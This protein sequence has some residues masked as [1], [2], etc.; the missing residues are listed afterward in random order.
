M[1]TVTAEMESPERF[2]R[3]VLQQQ[4]T[5]NE[6]VIMIEINKLLTNH[7]IM[8][9]RLVLLNQACQPIAPF[10]A[11]YLHM[12]YIKD[13]LR[14]NENG[15]YVDEN[16]TAVA[17]CKDDR[18]IEAWI[19]GDRLKLMKEMAKVDPLG[20]ITATECYDFMSKYIMYLHAH[21]YR[22]AMRQ[23][24]NGRNINYDDPNE[25]NRRK[26][27]TRTWQSRVQDF[28]NKM[29]KNRGARGRENENENE[30]KNENENENKNENRRK[31]H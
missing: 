26:L 17:E 29:N 4:L 6:N 9:R 13:N 21:D 7:R 31:L 1:A 14:Y 10:N 22:L 16:N 12:G 28:E 15:T 19:R 2:M 24:C 5:D 30:N 11:N 20:Q 18:E 25:I 8:M 27:Q 3:R 23:Y